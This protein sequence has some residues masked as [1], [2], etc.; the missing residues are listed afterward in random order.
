MS[1][2]DKTDNFWNTCPRKLKYRPISHCEEGKKSVKLETPSCDWWINSPEHNYCFW[3]Y[4]TDNSRPD[5]SMKEH[6]QSELSK[7]LKIPESKLH[8]LCKEAEDLLSLIM[9]H[10]GLGSNQDLD[11]V[12]VDL[13]MI[14]DEDIEEDYPEELI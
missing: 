5:G 11:H 9:E 1:R 4:I 14:P 13:I 7:L 10:K 2:N 6:T 8:I 12:H 3:S